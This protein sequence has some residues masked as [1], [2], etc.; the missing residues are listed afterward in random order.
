MVK[1][2]TKQ[3]KGGV[4]SRGSGVRRLLTAVGV[5]PTKPKPKQKVIT[6]Y[7]HIPLQEFQRLERLKK[8]RRFQQPG[9][10]QNDNLEGVMHNFQKE[11]REQE[12]SQAL[13]S[14]ELSAGTKEHLR[15]ILTI[16]NKGSKDNA[17]MQRRLREKKLIESA[18]SLLN[19]PNIFL[20]NELDFT[21]VD[22]SNI[23]MAENVFKESENNPSILKP[24]LN[25]KTV[26]DTGE[27]NTLRF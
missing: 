20:K 27:E 5:I 18:T 26:L 15:R 13:H 11:K 7:K 4:K 25:S 2:K 1:K 14:K 10:L 9:K 12:L 8:I 3:I 22:Q 16:Q 23:L 24:R 19:T 17:E 21:N 6:R